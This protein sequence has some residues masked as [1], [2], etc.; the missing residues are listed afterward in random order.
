M[1]CVYKK[2]SLSDSVRRMDA[3]IKNIE[4]AVCNSRSI[5]L[6]EESNEITYQTA[7][8]YGAV[9][10]IIV[11]SDT[12]WNE[13]EDENEKELFLGYKMIFQETIM[14]LRDCKSCKSYFIDGKRIIV[15]FD[16]PK[17]S[18]IQSVVDLSAKISSL[19][20][21][22]RFKRSKTKSCDFHCSIGIHYGRLLKFDEEE[23]GHSGSKSIYLGAAIQKANQLSSQPMPDK[24]N[25]CIRLSSVTFQ[26][27]NPEYKKMFHWEVKYSS[28]QSILY[29]VEMR[30]WLKGKG[31]CL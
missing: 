24:H 8:V 30:K 2:Y 13:N 15:V 6:S 27:L 14:L 26:N 10:S 19:I 16:T 5:Q 17:K 1:N 31:A 25:T 3:A 20:E 29:N 12:K 18:G 7:Y 9:M 21:I 22:W 4:N 28:Y 23:R 11:L